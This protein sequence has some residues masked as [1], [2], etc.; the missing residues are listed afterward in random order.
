MQI[1]CLEIQ[2]N[3]DIA[4]AQR[5]QPSNIPIYHPP[6]KGL[7]TGTLLPQIHTFF[8]APLYYTSCCVAY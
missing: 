8:F 1:A 3:T 2:Q 4:P 7:E 6:P 5:I